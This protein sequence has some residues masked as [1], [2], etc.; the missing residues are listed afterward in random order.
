MLRE[1]DVCRLCL[2]HRDVFSFTS[3]PF[4][5]NKEESLSPAGDGGKKRARAAGTSVDRGA[6]TQVMEI[7]GDVKPRDVQ[8]EPSTY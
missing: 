2:L 3:Y 7:Q 4:A 6:W 8:L 5:Q 1:T